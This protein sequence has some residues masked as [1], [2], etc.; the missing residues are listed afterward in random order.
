MTLFDLKTLK[1]LGQ[2]MTGENPDSIVYDP[3]SGRVFTF[4]G[5]SHDSTAFNAKSGKVEATIPLGGKPEFSV[6]DKKGSVFVNIED[7]HEIAVIDS[8]KMTVTK[9]YNLEGC[10]EPSGL[11]FDMA[12]RHLF[13]VCGNKVM[14]ISDP[15]S[16][17]VLATVPTGAGTDGAGFDPG[18]G[19]AF[20]SNGEGTLTL[21]REVNGKYQVV[22]NVKTERGARTMTVDPKTHRVFLSAAQY[23]PT[24][25][26][27]QP[28][29]RPP[30][31]PGTFGVLVVGQ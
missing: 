6:T 24:P 21:V 29:R 31:L 7:K 11:A 25:A 16:G 14:V 26:G 4:N 20:S 8:K 3:A 13:S 27:Q 9:R 19:T 10:E 15:D 30:V 1:P 5:R 22:Q 23:A 28:P 12:K 2:V 18:T 17:K